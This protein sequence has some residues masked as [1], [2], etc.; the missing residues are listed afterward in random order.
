MD[1]HADT[2]GDYILHMSMNGHH[3]ECMV[4]GGIGM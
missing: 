4:G 1:M 3:A 2:I